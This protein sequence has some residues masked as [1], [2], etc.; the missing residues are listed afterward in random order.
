MTEACTKPRQIQFVACLLLTTRACARPKEARDAPSSRDP[1]L[2]SIRCV[3]RHRLLREYEAVRKSVGSR[4]GKLIPI[5]QSSIRKINTYYYVFLPVF[6]N[7]V[8]IYSH[9]P[10]NSQWRCLLYIHGSGDDS[11][12]SRSPWAAPIKVPI[13]MGESA[14]S[15]LSGTGGVQGKTAVATEQTEIISVGSTISVC[16]SGLSSLLTISPAMVS[17]V[18]ASRTRRTPPS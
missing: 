2:K 4:T 12:L 10:M 5:I 14:T 11:C 13:R 17:S 7:F 3:S 9:Q 1:R 18:G 16:R 15:L 8:I 6:P